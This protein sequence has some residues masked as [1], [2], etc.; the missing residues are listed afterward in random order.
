MSRFMG[1][2]TRTMIPNSLHRAM[3]WRKQIQL[4]AEQIERSVQ[5]RGRTE[6]KTLVSEEGEE[7]WVQDLKTGKWKDI[8]VIESACVA[9]DG[10]IKSYAVMIDGILTSRHRRFLAKV[11]EPHSGEENRERALVPGGS[12]E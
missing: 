10:T 9:D 6:G 8:G 1:Q 2:A 4:R 3:D 7:V 5:K 12:Q 11:V